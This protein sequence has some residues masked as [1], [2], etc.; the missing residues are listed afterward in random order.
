MLIAPAPVARSDTGKVTGFGGILLYQPVGV[1][2]GSWFL[3]YSKFF[4]LI[5]KGGDSDVNFT[6]WFEKSY[7]ICCCKVAS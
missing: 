3:N 4:T 2:I 5:F 7:Q 1:L 6:L